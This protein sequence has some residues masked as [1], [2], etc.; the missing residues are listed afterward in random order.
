MN[1]AAIQQSPA[2]NPARSLTDMVYE[3]E[4]NKLIPI[5]ERFA[6][7]VHGYA[8]KGTEEEREKWCAAWNRTFHQKMNQLWSERNN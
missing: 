4:R 2:S 8:P 3:A 6:N 7:E 1:E 5:A